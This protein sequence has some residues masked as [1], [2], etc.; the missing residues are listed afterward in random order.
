MHKTLRPEDSL[1]VVRIGRPIVS[2]KG[3]LAFTVVRPDLDRNENIVEVW[4]HLRDG[5]KVYFTGE[6]DSSPAWSPSGR[7]AFTSRRGAGKE[8]KGAGIYTYG[9]A[10]DARRIAWFKHGIWALGWLDDDRL[11]VGSFEPESWMYDSDGDYV[12]TDRLPLWFDRS[13][14]IAGKTR[15]LYLVDHD[16]GYTARMTSEKY[17]IAGFAACS[18]EIYYY[19]VETW[20]RPYIHVLKRLVPGREPEVIARGLSIGEMACSRGKLYFTAHRQEIGIS[21]HYKL[22]TLKG[23]EPACLTCSL[24]DRNIWTISKGSEGVYLVYTDRG[25]GVLARYSEDSGLE[26]ILRGD[27]IVYYSDYGAERTFVLMTDPTTPPDIY[28]VTG[29]GLE[30]VTG[31]NKWVQ[32]LELATPHYITLTSEGEEIDGWV[33]LPPESARRKDK[34]P[35][36]LFIHGGPKGMYGYS[37]HYEHQLYAANGFIVAYA[38]PHG[39]DGYKEQFADIRGRYGEIDYK[40]LMDFLDKVI[41]DYPVDEEKLA[42]TGISY[43]GYMTNV[44]VTKTNRFAA[45]VPENGI[46][47]WIA[48][49]WAADIGFWF[50]PDQIGGTPLDNLQGY[51]DKSPAFKAENVKTP[52]LIIHSMEDYRCFIDQALAMHTAVKTSG[53]DS[54]LVVFTKGPHGHSI[55]ASPRHRRKRLEIKLKWIKEKLGLT[56]EGGTPSPRGDGE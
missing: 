22:Y 25:R 50:D 26:D 12:A 18:G 4:I 1:R 29:N 3:D 47:D 13:G 46:A 11:L 16:S 40:Q 20:E 15:Q 7:L 27:F 34:M 54:T 17:G 44:I 41:E 10:G 38:N 49:Y 8:E 9:H 56:S 52:L 19:S 36:I 14:L 45:A 23:G 31:F 2:E 5:R 33:L 53:G 35:L 24:L 48:D 42:V 43:G 32:E 28:E 21:S 51:I 39:S 30:R 55:T 6:G 37:F